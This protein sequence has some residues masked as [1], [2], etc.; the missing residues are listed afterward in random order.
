M[1]VV[2]I[3]SSDLRLLLTRMLLAMTFDTAT[4]NLAAVGSDVTLNPVGGVDCRY[5]IS[6]TILRLCVLS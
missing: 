5:L 1:L 2:C 6:Q 3:L 4:F